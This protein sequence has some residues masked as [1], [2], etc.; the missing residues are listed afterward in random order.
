MGEMP[1]RDDQ[2]A[3]PETAEPQRVTARLLGHAG[4]ATAMVFLLILAWLYWPRGARA[5]TM[6]APIEAARDD[7]G[8]PSGPRRAEGASS[9]EREAPPTVRVEAS[10]RA[11]VEGPEQVS[12]SPPQAARRQ[13]YA[14]PAWNGW[15]S[16]G[17]S[18][19]RSM[20]IPTG[21]RVALRSSS[22]HWAGMRCGT[23]PWL[24]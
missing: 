13:T 24:L 16:P 8:K 14:A 9:G 12:T 22:M 3:V 23:L 18:R 4:A 11:Q 1:P 2:D 6:E 10:A 15:A 21:V 20:V 17:M 7:S 5:A 19:Q